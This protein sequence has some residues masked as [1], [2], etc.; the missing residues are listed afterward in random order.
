MGRPGYINLT[1]FGDLRKFLSKL[2][3]QRNNGQI[4]SDKYKD[5]IYGCKA[6]QSCLESVFISEEIETRLERLERAGKRPALGTYPQS[7]DNESKERED[8]I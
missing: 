8:M 4:G 3:N 1:S 5:L 7:A 6:L 2:I